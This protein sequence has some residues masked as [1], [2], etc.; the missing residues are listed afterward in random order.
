MKF[1]FISPLNNPRPIKK[2]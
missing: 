2:D 1:K